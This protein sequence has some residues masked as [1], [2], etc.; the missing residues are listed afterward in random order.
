MNK[1]KRI[2]AVILCICSLSGTVVYA[3]ITA[4][5]P[6]KE[7]ELWT[8]SPT[9]T[10]GLTAGDIRIY[11]ALEQ[12]RLDMYPLEDLGDNYYLAICDHRRTDGGYSGKISTSTFY[13]YTLYETETGFIVL[14][15]SK[16]ENECY[17]NRG[18]SFSNV[19]DKIDAQ[20]YRNNGSEIPYY[21]FTT[22]GKY[23]NNDM[24]YYS[25]FWF[26]T[27]T[28]K[29][30]NFCDIDDNGEGGYP[31]I[32]D[33]VMYRGQ[34]KYT[35]SSKI[36]TYY[37]SDGKTAASNSKPMSFINGTI[38]L[39]TAEK[40]AVADMVAANGYYLYKDGFGSNVSPASYCS[41]LGSDNLYF[42]TDLASVYD[43]TADKT[44]MHIN[45]KI[46]KRQNGKM[47]L[48]NSKFIPT[49][50]TSSFSYSCMNINDL[51]AEF[52]ISN[53]MP[54]PAVMVDKYAV[55]TRDGQICDLNLD[56]SIYSKHMYFGTYNGKLAVIRSCNGTS[57]I[58]KKVEG[59]TSSAY[60]QAINEIVFD[61]N[62]GVILSEDIFLK[63]QSKAHEGQNGY[64][65]EED[66]WNESSFTENSNDAV[67]NWWGRT[68]SNVFPDGRYVAV[69]LKKVS[70]STYEV[71][72]RVYNADGT[73]RATAATG[74]TT[75][76]SSALDTQQLVIWA[77]KDT[78]FVFSV[79]EIDTSEVKEYYRVAVVKE[80][81]DGEVSG[82]VEI[83]EKSI[84]PPADSDTEVVQ[85]TIDF[86]SSEL[87]LGY[88][89]K[90]NVI[91]TNKLDSGLREQVNSIRLNDIVI[92][93]REG[94]Q[95][96][97]QNTG[98]AL[99]QYSEYDDSLGTSTVRMYTNGQ[100]FRWYCNYPE[101]LA[102][103]IYS[104]A[105]PIGDK[106]VYIT[107]KIVAPP[108]NEGSTTVVF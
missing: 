8:Q 14:S 22:K 91:D 79:K 108:T 21:V 10:C 95:S 98:V 86:G 107:F 13:I 93:M 4:V 102:P 59:T 74:F 53:D 32:K 26:I 65:S 71:W 77:I 15:E 73:M 96:G 90:D 48:Y 52:Y 62:N 3:E 81:V 17:W 12:N 68:L 18:Y 24:T 78:K 103:G 27:N 31:Y 104:K 88:N 51:D 39:G 101:D 1:L 34:E 66:V 49:T 46:Y 99:D 85:S 100:Y 69:T 106:T 84:T 57:Y 38:V 64:F 30:Y 7:Y 28:G 55:I 20:Y 75:T 72:Y 36:G 44:Y 105:I 45:I 43:E 54:V 61:S 82:K 56:T 89:I 5:T 80:S 83:G 58:Y 40:V 6:E 35:S 33:G 47:T 50:K 87:P 63:I 25:E 97:E 92:V 19:L 23:Y 37:M 2:F 76:A 29:I 60:H 42:S 67:K 70:G 16:T 11:K 94:Y 9:I 41:V